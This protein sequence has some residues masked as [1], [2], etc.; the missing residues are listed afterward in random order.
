MKFWANWYKTC[1]VFNK[2]IISLDK[3]STFVDFVLKLCVNLFEM[4]DL[5][6]SKIF[7][8]QSI[9]THEIEWTTLSNDLTVIHETVFLC[10]K[11]GS[12]TTVLLTLQIKNSSC[13][14]R[15]GGGELFS[16]FFYVVRMNQI[17]HAV[18]KPISLKTQ[19][20]IILFFF[21]DSNACC[22]QL[23]KSLNSGKKTLLH[24]IYWHF[25]DRIN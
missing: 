11:K 18:P 5:L 2:K 21:N 13:V 24:H 1:D 23:L 25:T 15:L 4:L 7:I 6:T 20:S 10:S 22:K 12:K 19:R 14:L 3:W 16:N 17:K 9:K 8:H